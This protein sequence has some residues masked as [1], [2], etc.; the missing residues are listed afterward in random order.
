MGRI[1]P[2]EIRDYEFKQSPLGYSKDQVNQ[3]L[4]EIAD[5]M[6]TLIKESNEIHVDIK[7]LEMTLK[8][9]TNVED[10]L[11]ETLV[12]AQKTAQEAISNAHEEA[13]TIRRKASTERE[14]L[15]FSANEDLSAIKHEIRKLYGQR[16][17]IL[18]KLKNSLKTNLEVL[19]DMFSDTESDAPNQAPA[20]L[21][22]ER[23]VDFSKS[24]LV[25]EDLMQEEESSDIEIEDPETLD[26]E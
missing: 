8:T 21:Q 10:S 16:D 3:F 19:E 23:I 4:G 7:A 6:E 15:L 24:D 9:Y 14:A 26:G 12:L 2:Q 11:K 25:V 5:E 20:D 13:E 17:S 22:D 18:V 1:S